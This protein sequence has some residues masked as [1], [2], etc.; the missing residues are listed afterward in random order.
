MLPSQKKQISAHRFRFPAGDLPGR[1]IKI[2]TD[3]DNLSAGMLI[4]LEIFLVPDLF[5]SNLGG[6]V[7]LEL[8]NENMITVTDYRIDP[9]VI[10]AGLHFD[11]E[12]E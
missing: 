4:L 6:L 1:R 12:P 10:R 11:I 3:Q 5:Q 9:T 8:K 2:G 7:D